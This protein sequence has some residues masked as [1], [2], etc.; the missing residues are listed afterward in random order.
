[1]LFYLYNLATDKYR[2]K[3]A[4]LLK[5]FLYLACLIYGLIVR[6]LIFIYRLKPHRLNCKVISVGNITL[7]GTGKTSLVAF[8]AKYLKGQ[9]HKVAILSRGYKRK[10]TSYDSIGDEPYMLKMNLRDVAVIV[11]AD[12]VR[13]AKHAIGDYGV[14][15]VIL[16][17]GFQQ[18]KIK[19]DLEI[20][21]V[22]CTNPFGNGYLIPR[23]I[24]REPLSSLKRADTFVLTKTNLNPDVQ[25]IKDFLNRLNPYALIIESIHYPL[26]FFK[27]DEEQ[28]LLK[29][30]VLKGSTVTLMSGIADP[31][32]FENLMVTLGIN[33][34]LV[35]RFPDHY[36]YAQKDLEN[37]I[38]ES[39]KKHIDTIVTTEKD[40]AR[41]YELRVTS[42]EL[43]VLFLRIELKITRDEQEFY[44]RLLSLYSH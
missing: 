17:D 43:R 27:V 14:D 23:G 40:A 24:L 41:L 21:T 4:G 32:S 18:W 42:Y 6:L 30:D 13:G 8:I 5:I 31:D 38:E 35:F 28:E 9:G 36:A 16:D 2:G 29:I 3:L 7:G 11:D 39:R 12:R 15:T 20:V 19:K 33:I 34:G 25:D 44:N 10:V 37:I 1:M 26:G 22:D